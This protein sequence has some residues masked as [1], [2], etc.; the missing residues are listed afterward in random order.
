MRP[1]KSLRISVMPQNEDMKKSYGGSSGTGIGT[2]RA[3]LFSP[4][5]AVGA[6]Y[7]PVPVLDRPI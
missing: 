7:V 5:A 3:P 4:M 6:V 2:R 1:N